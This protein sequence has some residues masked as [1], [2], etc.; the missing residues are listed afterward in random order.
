M[1]LMWIAGA[2]VGW[3]VTGFVVGQFTKPIV[4]AW[5]KQLNPHG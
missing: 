1:G 4:E 3:F 2:V 5:I